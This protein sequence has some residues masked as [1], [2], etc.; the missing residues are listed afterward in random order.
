MATISEYVGELV[1]LRCWC[2][3]QHAVPSTLRTEQLRKRENGKV[4]SIF[5]PLGHTHV[6]AGE[7]ES[8]K[9]RRE[10]M[11]ERSAHDQTRA[12][13]EEKRRQL[14]A[15]KGRIT[16]AKNRAIAGLCPV[17]GCKRHFKNL[18]QHIHTQHPDFKQS[19]E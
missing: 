17:P 2:G 18:D 1:V 5:C 4:M 19:G 8:E 16:K 15:A 9:L 13:V 14:I 7:L 12:C 10:L 11:R 6:P 3:I